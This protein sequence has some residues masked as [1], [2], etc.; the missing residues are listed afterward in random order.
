M[1]AKSRRLGSIRS[2]FVVTFSAAAVAG[3][4]CGSVSGHE[5]PARTEAELSLDAGASSPEPDCG[6]GGY[7]TD[8]DMPATTVDCPALAPEAGS[9]CDTTDQ[10]EYAD[11][12]GVCIPPF[13][14]ARCENGVWV[15]TIVQV[16]CNPPEFQ[17]IGLNGDIGD[18]G[19]DEFAGAGTDTND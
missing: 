15:V 1:P 19:V 16:T 18:A 6:D 10:C 8:G 13:P 4:G 3:P 2:S 11:L 12:T 14:S 9:A 7:G 17:D 5:R